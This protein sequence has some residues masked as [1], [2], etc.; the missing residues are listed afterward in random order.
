MPTIGAAQISP[1]TYA[2]IE[3]TALG[4]ACAFSVSDAIYGL[5]TAIE[6]DNGFWAL[7]FG[8]LALV[9][10]AVLVPYTNAQLERLHRERTS[11]GEA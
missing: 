1:P 9:S 2:Q 4:L 6:L 3:S 11:R 5:V 8:G 7:P 10:L